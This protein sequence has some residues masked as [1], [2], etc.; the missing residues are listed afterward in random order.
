MH[1]YHYNQ[2]NRKIEFSCQLEY[3]QFLQVDNVIGKP[4]T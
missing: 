2:E 1:M 4:I 3:D